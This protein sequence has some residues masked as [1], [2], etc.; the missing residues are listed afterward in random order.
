V[1]A[2]RS[3]HGSARTAFAAEWLRLRTPR[4]LLWPL[5]AAGAGAL[6]AVGLS[7]AA[8]QRLLGGRSGYWVAAAALSGCQ[9]AGALIAALYSASGL[10][11][12]AS[13]GLLR[14]ALTRP[15]ARRA[16]A[17]GRLGAL[18]LGVALLSTAAAAG[19]LLVAQLRFGLDA[20]TEGELVI[21][22]GAWLA[23]QL[24]LAFALSLGAQV[25][26]AALGGALGLALG[27]AGP[28]VVATAAAGAGL[29]ALS[30]WPAVER[31]LPSAWLSTGLDRV[32]QL[33]L[34]LSVPAPSDSA[35]E[36]A[37]N[38]LLWCAAGFALA[39]AA[40]ERKDITS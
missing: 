30:R 40:V 22:S 20:A 34:G 12:D 18:A 7:I 15:L 11:A 33:A 16:W 13:S 3:G 28:A 36:A 4:A 31:L 29:A 35:L 23:G 6:Y 5:F 38:V 14:T 21:S 9:S 2:V 25:A 26:A 27:A 10:A 24:G 37:F 19:A 1:S 17:A 39:A 32:A 8:E